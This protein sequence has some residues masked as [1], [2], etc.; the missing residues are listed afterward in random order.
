MGSQFKSPLQ[1]LSKPSTHTFQRMEQAG[2]NAFQNAGQRPTNTFPG[3]GKPRISSMQ[4]FE[5]RRDNTARD[6][7]KQRGQVAYE[8]KAAVVQGQWKAKKGRK[9][10]RI[11]TVKCIALAGIVCLLLLLG[12]GGYWYLH[13]NAASLFANNTGGG[14]SHSSAIS[15]VPGQGMGSDG[16]ALLSTPTPTPAWQPYTG[17]NVPLMSISA[18]DGLVVISISKQNL[19]VYDKGQVVF[20]SLVTTGRSEE[21]RVGKDCICTWWPDE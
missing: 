20:V 15:R 6:N 13:A 19:T 12:E 3:M 5:V 21:R 14:G 16:K 17:P 2:G 8:R 4:G 9:N 7:K 11:S 1:G 18:Q 10:R